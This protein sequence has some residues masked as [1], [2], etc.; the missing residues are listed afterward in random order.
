MKRKTYSYIEYLELIETL[1][2]DGL[3]SGPKQSEALSQF[4]ALN[5]KRMQRL[6][7]TMQTEPDVERALSEL[8][9]PQHWKVITE[10]WCGDSAQNIPA[11]AHIAAKS[12][13]KIELAM[14]LRDENLDLMDRFLTNGG[15]SI[16]KL[17]AFDSDGNE[18]FTWG[19][20][21]EEAQKLFRVWKVNQSDMTWE[22][23]EKELHTWYAKDRTQSIQQELASLISKTAI[24]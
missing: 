17:I 6:N 21:P 20:R 11:I 14:V 5:L 18:L 8:E 7:K 12:N 19:P 15:R 22:E 3:T 1:V 9:K 24:S 4:T 23:F 16:P 13:G 2:N 10:A